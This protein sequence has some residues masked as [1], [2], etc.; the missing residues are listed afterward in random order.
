MNNNAGPHIGAEIPIAFCIPTTSR[1][2]DWRQVEDTHLWRILLPSLSS[3]CPGHR[4]TMFIGYDLGD[5]IFEE[6]KNQ[7]K[8]SSTF[9]LFR[10]QWFGFR[11]EPGNVV[12]IWNNLA[13]YAIEAGHEYLKILGDDIRF[14]NDS[15]WLSAMLNKLKRNNNVGWAAGWSNNDDIATQF[16]IH[17]THI[18]IYGSVFPA[19]LT[20][21]YCDDFMNQ[22]YPAKYKIW[23]KSFPLLNCGG[24][25]RYQPRDDQQL[26]RM[27]VHRVRPKLAAFLKNN[28]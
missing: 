27:L 19:Q 24:R 12:R 28:P 25:P 3:Y 9:N 23:L 8:I 1:S 4:I 7:L 10:F 16:L 5:P 17:K 18:R 14:P 11:P 13:A 15:Y 22:I 2:T 20:N 26:C 6:E 21:Y